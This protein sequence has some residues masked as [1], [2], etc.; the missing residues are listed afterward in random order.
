MYIEI[1]NYHYYFCGLIS[2]SKLLIGGESPSPV[3]AHFPSSGECH[4]V[5][6]GVGEWKGKHP[7][8][9]RRKGHG[10]GRNL[11]IG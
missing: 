2:F 3:K 10:R 11:E 7:H 1:F 4:T 9:S 5:E 8:R 6:M